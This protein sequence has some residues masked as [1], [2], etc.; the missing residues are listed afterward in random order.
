MVACE[1]DL[2]ILPW[3]TEIGFDIEKMV[4]VKYWWRLLFSRESYLYQHDQGPP[5][6]VCK[7]YYQINAYL[8]ILFLL[9][10]LTKSSRAP[11]NL[12]SRHLRPSVNCLIW[13]AKIL[14]ENFIVPIW[15]LQHEF[16]FLITSLAATNC[17]TNDI[18][19]SYFGSL[20]LWN[21]RLQLETKTFWFS[22]G[23]ISGAW[24]HR[25]GCVETPFACL[26]SN[27]LRFEVIK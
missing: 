13:L 27:I 9:Q 25:F 14:S 1:N 5:F 15:F 8:S 6:L 26:C 23:R 19:L 24:I 12:D 16:C 11:L 17:W 3:R 21:F 20:D 4:F 10:I 18:N 7:S 2:E 22:K